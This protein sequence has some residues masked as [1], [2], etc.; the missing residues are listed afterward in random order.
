MVNGARPMGPTRRGMLAGACAGVLGVSG[1]VRAACSPG[2]TG[3][4]QAPAAAKP[5]ITL[6]FLNWLPIA[7]EQFAT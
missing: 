3:T 7:M 5:P 6:S 2:T 4:G 1:A